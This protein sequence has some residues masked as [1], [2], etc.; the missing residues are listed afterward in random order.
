MYSRV[1][2]NIYI[3]LG[4]DRKSR[5][6]KTQKC[7]LQPYFIKRVNHFWVFCTATRMMGGV[8]AGG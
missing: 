1:N 7:G 6:Y 4:F 2:Q 3:L 8:G 5:V